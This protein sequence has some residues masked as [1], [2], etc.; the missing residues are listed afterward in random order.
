MYIC[1]VGVGC[2]YIIMQLY[3]LMLYLF[4][5]HRFSAPGDVPTLN[6]S[7]VYAVKTVLQRPLSL[8]Q[9]CMYMCTYICTYNVHA[10]VN[11]SVYICNFGVKC[12]YVCTYRDLQELEK[13]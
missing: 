1:V 11:C 13:Q 10:R 8:I 4:F 2:M 12:M 6:S 5:G 7:Q 9:V 3:R